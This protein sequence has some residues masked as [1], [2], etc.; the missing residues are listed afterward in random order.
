MNLPS[1]PRPCRERPAVLRFA[2]LAWLKFQWLC[3]RGPTEVGG[4]GL[5]AEDDPLHVEDLVTVAQHAT[6]A[7]VRFEDAAVAD[8]FDRCA[9]LGIKPERCGRVWLHTHPGGSALPSPLDEDTFARCF[10]RCDWAIMA[11][12]ARGGPAYAR[13]AL[14]AGPGAEV[15]LAVAVAWADWPEA[16]RSA[17]ALDR[18]AGSWEEAYAAHVKPVPLTRP[19]PAAT[20]VAAAG[21]PAVWWESLAWD[22][23]LDGVFY[24]PTYLEEE[25]LYEPA[26]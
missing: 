24:E 10:G 4:F 20:A 14:A 21:R 22:E 6:A 13:L 1:P 23:A 5:S 12:L 8:H 19:E 17:G 11:I 16:L 7:G 18:L 15:E 3:H 25:E 26:G 2:P 9:D